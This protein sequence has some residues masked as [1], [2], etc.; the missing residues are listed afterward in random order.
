VIPRRP[1]TLQHRHWYHSSS[2]SR[3]NPKSIQLTVADDAYAHTTYCAH[4]PLALVS[5]NAKSGV[6][7]KVICCGRGLESPSVGVA[8]DRGFEARCLGHYAGGWVGWIK[9]GVR[10]GI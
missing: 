7:I 9:V 6:H 3:S 1:C 5:G 2:S 10:G 4:G 8:E